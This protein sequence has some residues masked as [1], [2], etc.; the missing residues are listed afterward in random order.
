MP[1]GGFLSPANIFL[2]FLLLFVFICLPSL[3]QSFLFGAEHVKRTRV[4]THYH[5]TIVNSPIQS[6]P[7]SVVA[8]AEDE[9]K[10]AVT[11]LLR[12]GTKL[13]CLQA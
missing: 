6:L 2:A 8:T 4:W 1:A 9:D 13:A 12:V 7:R 11:N 10:D 3:H 5:T